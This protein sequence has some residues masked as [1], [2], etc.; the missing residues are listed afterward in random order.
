[1]RK[2]GWQDGEIVEMIVQAAV[3]TLFNYLNRAAETETDF[4][5]PAPGPKEP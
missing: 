3:T 5:D 1:M 4:P 2:L